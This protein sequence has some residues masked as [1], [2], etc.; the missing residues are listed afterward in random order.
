MMKATLYL[1]IS[2]LPLANCFT[3]DE[4][5]IRDVVNFQEAAQCD[6]GFVSDHKGARITKHIFA[7]TW[8]EG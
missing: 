2:V 3:Y 5:F 8:N 1:L 7:D 6:I 4:Q